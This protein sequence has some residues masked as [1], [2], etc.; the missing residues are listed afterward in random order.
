M[1]VFHHDLEAIE[2]LGFT[3][4]HFIDKVLCQILI[5]NTITGGEEGQ[6]MLDE[7]TLVVV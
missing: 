1:D 3:V 5:H 6:N 2:K 7:I 4:L